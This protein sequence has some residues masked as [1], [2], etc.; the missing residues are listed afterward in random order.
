MEVG[1]MTNTAMRYQTNYAISELLQKGMEYRDCTLIS[2]ALW[3]T[4]TAVFA[5]H[6][7]QAVAN[8]DHG[9]G[10]RLNGTTSTNT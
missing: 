1:G 4:R 5:G 3:I 6:V 8:Q 7:S 9:I 2:S 10:G